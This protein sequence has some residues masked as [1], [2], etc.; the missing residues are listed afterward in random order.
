MRFTLPDIA[1]HAPAA[2]PNPVLTAPPIADPP[3]SLPRRV[4][5]LAV[6]AALGLALAGGLLGSLWPTAAVVAGA[7]VLILALCVRAPAHAFLAA[8][9]LYGFEGSIKMRLSVEGVP[10]PTAFGAVLLDFAFLAA[11]AN[12]VVRDG[13]RSLARMWGAA[14]RL[15]RVAAV[16]FGAW[17][18]LSVLQIPVGGDLVNGLEG[19]R[20]TQFYVPAL[21]G[22]IVVTARLGAE[23]LTPLLMGV[24]VLATAYAAVRGV[25]GPSF[26][27]QAF[28]ESR[29]FHTKFGE[30]GRNIG[31]FTSP[32]ALVSFLAPVAVLCLTLGFLLPARRSV[33]WALAAL[34]MVGI[35]GSFVRSALAA[36]VL[37]AALLAVLVVL[38]SEG[39][40]RRKTYAVG[41]V[42]LLVGGLFAAAVVA[43]EVSPQT[44]ARADSLANPFQ[45]ES[46]KNRLDTWGRTLERVANEPLG[47]GVGTVGRATKRGRRAVT[48]DNSYMKVLQ[49]QGV[50][51]GLLFLAGLGG[52]VF[53]LALRLARIGVTR[54]PLG[55][56]ALTGFSGFLVLML[57]GE[58]VEQPGKLLA[59]TLLGVAAWEAIG[60]ADG[61]PARGTTLREAFARAKPVPR[62]AVAL[63]VGCALL[64]GLVALGLAVTRE[65]DYRSSSRLLVTPDGI[66]DPGLAVAVGSRFIQRALDGPVYQA[67][68]AAEIDY[69]PPAE[70]GRRV[71]LTTRP[72]RELWEFSLTAAGRSPDAARDLA[73]STSP[74]LVALRAIHRAA[75]TEFERRRLRAALRSGVLAPGQRAALRRRLDGLDGRL[76]RPV[77]RLSAVSSPPPSDHPVD[78]LADALTSPASPAPTPAWAGFAGLMFGAAAAVS[79]LLVTVPRRRDPW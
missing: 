52:L 45:D 42:A 41:L 50:L 29:T 28:A 72:I 78:K 73:R 55:A 21:L 71:R 76:L 30:L 63:A 79:L 9:V 22:G 18:C 75:V 47:T 62:A 64:A 68:V 36:V 56:A 4:P 23:R 54:R 53:L 49:E 19:F 39:G 5:G 2:A 13:G 65:N 7:V 15:E 58:Y 31:S 12:L 46:V 69:L 24:V 17:L 66:P 70:V 60:R 40:R 44:R 10:S 20:L 74:A 6:A 25:T 1:D 43:G 11:L 57:M 3:P 8:L 51:G 48:T 32:V 77:S 14:T 35:L 26:N 38:G 67:A 59:W 16:L 34:A 33:A 37:G 61:G 27:E